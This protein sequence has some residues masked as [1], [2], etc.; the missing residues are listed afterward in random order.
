MPKSITSVIDHK[1][2]IREVEVVISLLKDYFLAAKDYELVITD[3]ELPGIS[4]LELGK[5]SKTNESR[6]VSCI[7]NKHWNLLQKVIYRSISIYFEKRYA[8]KV[9]C[10]NR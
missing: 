1:E 6:S 5:K 10:V 9:A 7:L 4:G 8:R 2:E 3:I